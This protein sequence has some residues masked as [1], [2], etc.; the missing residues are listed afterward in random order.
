MSTAR[1]HPASAHLSFGVEIHAQVLQQ[2]LEQN[3]LPLMPWHG[4]LMSAALA[5]VGLATAH[6]SPACQ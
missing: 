3:I 1:R 5:G 6:C 4:T 2:V